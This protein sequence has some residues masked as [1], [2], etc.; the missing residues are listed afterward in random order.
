MTFRKAV[1]RHVLVTA[2]LLSLIANIA[3]AAETRIEG[4][5]S[6]GGK[7]SIIFADHPIKAMTE[8]PFKIELHNLNG[9]SITAASLK[10][11]LT[12]P[13]MPMPPNHPEA[14]WSGEDYRGTAIFTMAGAWQ[15]NVDIVRSGSAT[16]KIVFD[17]EMVVMQ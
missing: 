14:V 1:F 10:L 9:E 7:A 5:L 8:T 16:E 2:S 17:I 3:T 6:D 13:F 12:M 11:D 15:V 4:V